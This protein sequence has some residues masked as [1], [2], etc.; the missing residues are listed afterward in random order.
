MTLPKIICFSHPAIC[1]S[2]TLLSQ[3]TGTDTRAGAAID[4]TFYPST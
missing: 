2:D 3:L 1:P 4:H